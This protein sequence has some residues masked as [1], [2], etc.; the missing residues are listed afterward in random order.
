VQQHGKAIHQDLAYVGALKSLQDTQEIR[1]YPSIL[2]EG[3]GSIS[4]QGL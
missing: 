3:R 2:P 4:V 1:R